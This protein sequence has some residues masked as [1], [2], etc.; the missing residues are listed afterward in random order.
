MAVSMTTTVEG[1]FG[2]ALMVNGFILDNQLTDFSFEPE[3]DDKPVANA[4]GPGKHPL[5][6]M[7]PVIV[8]DPQGKF[9]FAAGSPGGPM[10]I[11]YVAQSLIG[12]IDGNLTPQQAT[13]LPHPGNLNSPTLLEKGHGAGIS[14]GRSER[15][16]AHGCDAVRGEERPADH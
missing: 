3:F 16:G 15:D 12:L 10:I 8:L 7:S 14:H 11:D 4:P 13:A 5:S 1:P 9:K 6:S 2:S